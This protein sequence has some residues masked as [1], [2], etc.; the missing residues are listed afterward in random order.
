MIIDLSYVIIDLVFI[1]IKLYLFIDFRLSIFLW[2][3]LMYLNLLLNIERLSLFIGI[4]FDF[5]GDHI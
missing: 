3:N 4:I 2:L 1:N 5:T